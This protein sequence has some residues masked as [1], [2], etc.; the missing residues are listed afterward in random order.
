MNTMHNVRKSI[1]IG[2]AVLG[3]G[4]TALAA[5]AHDGRHGHAASQEQRHAKWTEHAAKRQAKLHEALKLSAAQEPAWGAFVAAAQPK[6]RAERG[7]REAWAAMSAP[8]R[9]E[10]RL[11]RAKRHIA[12]MET[13]LTALNTF[14]AVLTPEQK[15]VFDENSM[16]GGRG[17]H[18]R[19]HGQHR[20]QG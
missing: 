19:M 11:A 1:V 13:R 8:Q 10:Q 12:A 5:E 16:H 4:S 6:A 9:A 2:L 14:Y 17:M 20:M 18:G 15:K 7:D 3:M